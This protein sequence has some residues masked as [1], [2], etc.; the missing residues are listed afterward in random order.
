[1][2]LQRSISRR[3]TKQ[4]G[5]IPDICC[6]GLVGAPDMDGTEDFI[7]FLRESLETEEGETDLFP[8]IDRR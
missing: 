8:C 4:Q 1:M 5:Q 6:G 7:D 3:M 2:S